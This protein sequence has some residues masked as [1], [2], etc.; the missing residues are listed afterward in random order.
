M[1]VVVLDAYY[2]GG[3]DVLCTSRRPMQICPSRPESRM[4][5]DCARP[6]TPY[7]MTANVSFLKIYMVTVASKFSGHTERA[8]NAV[9]HV[10]KT[11]PILHFSQ[12]SMRLGKATVHANK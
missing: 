12:W 9:A 6:C 11:P 3:S 8:K 2:F 1:E 10:K 4:F 7:P 5:I